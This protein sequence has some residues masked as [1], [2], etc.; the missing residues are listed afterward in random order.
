MKSITRIPLVCF[1]FFQAIITQAQNY[2]A[3]STN[4]PYEQWN[5]SVSIA[6]S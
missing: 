3:S 2:C 1:L 5:Q 4:L 6:N